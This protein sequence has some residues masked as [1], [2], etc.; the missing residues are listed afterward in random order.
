MRATN[1]FTDSTTDFEADIED[2]NGTYI[3]FARDMVSD[4]IRARE[5]LILQYLPDIAD[6]IRNT[7]DKE[8]K[9]EELTKEI[10]DF[11][12]ELIEII[13]QADKQS[14]LFDEIRVGDLIQALTPHAPVN[15]LVASKV[16]KSEEDAAILIYDYSMDWNTNCTVERY[17]FFRLDEAARALYADKL[18]R[19]KNTVAML[20]EASRHV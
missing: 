15:G 10:V 5:D 17:S 13:K 19:R 3:M 11:N 18:E 12:L 9:I 8:R 1:F 6:D 4:S 20:G 7:R 2:E 14:V 16:G